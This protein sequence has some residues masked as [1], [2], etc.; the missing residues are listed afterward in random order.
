MNHGVRRFVGVIRKP[1]VVAALVAVGIMLLVVWVPPSSHPSTGDAAAQ[2]E[3]SRSDQS[4]DGP[5]TPGATDPESASVA[6]LWSPVDEADVD[7]LPRY[8]PRWSPEGRVLVRVAEAGRAAGGWQVG[9]RL[10]LPL[11]QLGVV[12]RPAIEKLDVGPGPSVSALGKILGDDGRRRRFVV[13]VGPAH[14]F[15]YIDTPRGP[16]E[17]TG[18]AELGWLLPSS[19]MM[20]GFDFSEPDY[21]LPGRRGPAASP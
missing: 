20:A 16:Y 3:A 12:Y 1:L 17:L 10:T 21:I 9:D 6:P 4:A 5:V 7:R 2:R 19:R 18:D 15:A 11:P 13:T 14:A 8:A